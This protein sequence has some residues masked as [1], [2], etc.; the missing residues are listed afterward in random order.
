MDALALTVYDEFEQDEERWFTL[1]F[2]A[3]GR[4]LVVSRTR[5]TCGIGRRSDR[6]YVS[7]QRDPTRATC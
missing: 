2:D 5:R 1:G 4:L 6:H 3:T 7:R